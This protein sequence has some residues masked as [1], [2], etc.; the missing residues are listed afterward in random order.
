MVSILNCNRNSSFSMILKNSKL[1]N[2]QRKMTKL[3]KL[4]MRKLRIKR[5]KNHKFKIKTKIKFK[6]IIIQVFITMIMKKIIIIGENLLILLNFC[7]KNLPFLFQKYCQKKN[8][9]NF[10]KHLW[11]DCKWMCFSQSLQ[12]LSNSKNLRIL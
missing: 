11:W 12:K 7:S 10:F 1:K 2:H 8:M 9:K 4:L 3:F 6:I 5:K